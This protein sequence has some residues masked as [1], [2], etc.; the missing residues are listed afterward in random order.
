MMNEGHSERLNY[1]LR[2]LWNI[3]MIT[4]VIL[5]FSNLF[6]EIHRKLDD[7]ISVA[8]QS[9]EIPSPVV[10]YIEAGDTASRQSDRKK[11]FSYYT[12]AARLS[13]KDYKK[14]DPFYCLLHNELADGHHVAISR[15]MTIKDLCLK[16]EAQ[17]GNDLMRGCVSG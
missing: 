7:A 2:R 11:A 12:E 14:G 6:A 10:L 5:V 3:S 13:L 16:M 9:E 15:C 8:T 1:Y 4:L 17:L